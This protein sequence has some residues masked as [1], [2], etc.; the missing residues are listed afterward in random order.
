[1]SEESAL[2]APAVDTP[3]RLPD[4]PVA[5]ASDTSG[6]AGGEAGGGAPPAGS[7]AA[8]APPLDPAVAA[9]C[10]PLPGGDPCGPDL[11]F[12]ADGPYLNYF[13]KADNILPSS[14]FSAED[15]KPFDRSTVDLPGML[16]EIKPIMAR[17]RDLRLLALRARILL[18]NKDLGG[19]AATVAAMAEWLDKS[20]DAIHPRPADGDLSS[21][22]TA[23][24]SIDAPPI[25][26]PLQYAPLYEIRRLGPISYRTWMI[27][28]GEVKPRTGEVK[29]PQSALTEGMADADPATLAASR[30]HIATIRSAAMRIRNAFLMQ[31]NS[32]NLQGLSA[33]IDKVL[34]FIDP[35]AEEA[36][37]VESDAADGGPA[38]GAAGAA[39][40]AGHAPATLVQAKA[41]LAAI[42]E[43]YSRHEPSSP[44]LPL[45]RQA[46]ELIGKSFLEVMTVLVPG[47]VENASFQIG[48]D[49]VFDLPL[50]K[51]SELPAIGLPAEAPAAGEQ[52]Q[53][54]VE[55][56]SQAIA[57]L[58]Q[59]QRYFRAAEPGS[60]VPMLCER[61]RALAERDFMGVLRD[62]LPKSALRNAGTDR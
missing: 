54:R 33:L 51:L 4:A 10:Q 25:I 44:T 34:A 59:V 11:D 23:V 57:L 50:G 12:E 8:Q 45:V 9:L 17:T 46:H 19:F 52:P 26:F 20:W 30:K 6:M 7:V 1:M 49:Q 32:C 13:A 18:L 27:A 22:V 39:R 40:P 29:H 15:G 41:A 5:G 55:S 61:A 56:R 2:P 53:Y 60:P 16:D 37:A 35:R 48:G 36:G 3:A 21:R 38:A 62:V 43:Y 28:S 58:D 31:G 42:S 47:Q 14:Y 24:S